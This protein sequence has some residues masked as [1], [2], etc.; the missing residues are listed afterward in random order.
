MAEALAANYEADDVLTANDVLNC[1]VSY[2]G[3]VATGEEVRWII[4]RIYG[5]EF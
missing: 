4:R 5:F 3:G 2:F 1:V